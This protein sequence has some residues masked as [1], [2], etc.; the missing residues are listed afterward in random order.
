MGLKVAKIPNL[1][2]KL[3]F[4]FNIN[5]PMDT[6][7]LTYNGEKPIKFFNNIVPLMKK[8]LGSGSSG[9][10]DIFLSYD[11]TDGSFKRYCQAKRV[12]DKNTTFW[13][14]ISMNGAQD[15]KSG[16]GKVTINYKT[17][18]D[19]NFEY[20]NFL[21]KALVNLYYYIYYKQIIKSHLTWGK[22]MDNNFKQGLLE[23]GAIEGPK[24]D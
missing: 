20:Y 3:K 18:F 14:G 21:Q 2:D 24:R 4:T 19:V 22:R 16:K 5:E 23:L 8:P 6:I 17:W 11:G 7:S 1:S 13:L 15:L 10:W 9:F 12:M